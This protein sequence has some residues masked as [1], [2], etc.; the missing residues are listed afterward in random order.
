MTNRLS[1]REEPDPIILDM[2]VLDLADKVM[3]QL[4]TGHDYGLSFIELDQRDIQHQCN[5]C[6][7]HLADYKISKE[8][9]EGPVFELYLDDGCM[10]HFKQ[11]LHFYGNNTLTISKN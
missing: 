5:F 4:F 7:E 1:D 9:L 8:V 2:I 3:G 11:F 10:N 6:G